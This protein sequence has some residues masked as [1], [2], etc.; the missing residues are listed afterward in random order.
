[1]FAGGIPIQ[2]VKHIEE[3]VKLPEVQS[4]CNHSGIEQFSR[5]PDNYAAILLDTVAKTIA[6][7]HYLSLT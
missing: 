6:A 1:M 7:C 3:I 5:D 4:W 2:N